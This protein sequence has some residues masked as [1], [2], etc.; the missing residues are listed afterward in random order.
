VFFLRPGH[1]GADCHE[2]G[3]VVILVKLKFL[4][5]EVAEAPFKDL[6]CWE[7]CDF[8]SASFYFLTPSIILH[9]T[10]IFFSGFAKILKP[11]GII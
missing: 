6:K 5:P 8:S 3:T 7:V 9:S 11:R 1:T 4:L 10:K 2:D